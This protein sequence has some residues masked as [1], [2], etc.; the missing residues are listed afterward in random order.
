MIQLLSDICMNHEDADVTLVV[1]GTKIPAHTWI[2]ST[3]STYFK[4]L[5]GGDFAE[6][7]Q[8]EIELK[9]PLSAIKAILKYIYTGQ[10]SLAAFECDEIVDMYDLANQY[11]FDSLKTTI[12]EYLTSN[13]T[14]GNCIEI[15][16]A[17][18]LYSLNDLQKACMKFM[19]SNATEL[20]GHE[21]FK[22]LSLNSLCALL[23]RDSFYAPEVEIFKAI[24]N[25][26]TSNLDADIK[27]GSYHIGTIK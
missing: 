5:F 14:L 27:V 10:M 7:K 2:L 8:S 16:N 23:K 12:L 20:L 1:D 26:H 21:T 18:H 6:S 22:E 3:R 9:V 25:W 17:A 11:G 24:C 15:W 4:S 13:L 19:D